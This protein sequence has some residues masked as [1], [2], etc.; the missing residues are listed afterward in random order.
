MKRFVPMGVVVMVVL[1]MLASS[2]AA[3]DAAQDSLV[4]SERAF[5]AMASAKSVKEAFLAY[6]SEDAVVFQPT[7]TNGRKAWEARPESKATLLWEPAFAVVSS[8][9]DLGYTT[10]PWEFRP[11][12]DSAGTAVPPER[13]S[14]G[15]FHSVWR[16][17]RHDGWKVVADIGVSHPKPDHGAVGSGEF[18]EGPTLPIRTMKP[19]RI[20]MGD[21][22]QKLSKTMRAVGPRDALAAHGAQ[23]LRLGLEGKLPAIG[24]EAALALIDFEGFLVYHEQGSGFASSGDL[25]YT[26]GWAERFVGSNP[27]PADSSVYLHVWKQDKGRTWLLAL[28]VLSPLRAH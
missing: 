19:S 23:D 11:A 2:P 3:A 27:A 21:L 15:H 25:G 22:D 13:Y 8:A 5:A 14:Y 26:Y 28:A 18:T 4:A 6:L 12:P 1:P 10:G 9:G 17:Q 24:I 7:A 16:R 20:H